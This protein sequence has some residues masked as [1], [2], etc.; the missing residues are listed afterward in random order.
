M[1]ESAMASETNQSLASER[2]RL[3][4]EKTQLERDQNKEQ[5]ELRIKLEEIQALNKKVS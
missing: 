2:T 4:L 1:R 5:T 3:E